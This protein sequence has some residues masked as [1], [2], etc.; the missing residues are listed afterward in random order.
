M[1]G[2]DKRF[3]RKTKRLAETFGQ[4]FLWTGMRQTGSTFDLPGEEFQHEIRADLAFH[5]DT[6]TSDGRKGGNDF[7]SSAVDDTITASIH[8]PDLAGHRH[9]TDGDL[10][11]SLNDGREY[12]VTAKGELEDGWI[13]LEIS[14]K[15]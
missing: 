4:P 12:K 10:L 5:S 14:L 11:K 6:Q 15:Q 9:P 13:V 8:L 3:E 1:D 2:F 7:R